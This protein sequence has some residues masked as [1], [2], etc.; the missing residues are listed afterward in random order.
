MTH[1]STA[2]HDFAQKEKVAEISS[3]CLHEL[4]EEEV[5]LT[6]KRVTYSDLITAIKKLQKRHKNQRYSVSHQQK[7]DINNT[8]TS[9]NI[10]SVEQLQHWAETDSQ[11]FLNTLNKLQEQRDLEISVSESVRDLIAECNYLSDDWDILTDLLAEEKTCVTFLNI[12]F[13]TFNTKYELLKKCQW[14]DYEETQLFNI[15]MLLIDRSKLFSKIS[16]FSFLDNSTELTWENWLS[17][18][19]VKLSVNENHY[20]TSITCMRYVMFQLSEKT[21]QHTESYLPHNFFIINFYQNMDKILKNLKEVYKNSV[22]SRNYC[23][24]YIELIQSFKQFFNFYVEFC[25]L[26]TFLE[27]EE[28]QYINHLWDK[29]FS[30]LQFSLSS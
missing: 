23:Q 26:S 10:I 8:D 15:S 19:C 1:E 29:I 16:D 24:T 11:Q 14:A 5:H 13:I 22:K 20:S 25:C 7:I 3:F 6:V 9:Y 27:Y 18:I 17:K 21:A 30:C 28:T 12:S 4:N 2:L